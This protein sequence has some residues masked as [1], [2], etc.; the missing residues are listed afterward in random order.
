MFDLDANERLNF[1][2]QLR[3]ELEISEDPL[4][5]VVDFWIR[6]PFVNQYLDPTDPSS[7]P[8][9]WHLILDGKYDDLAIC[10]GML[11]TIKLTQRFNQSKCEIHMS[12]DKKKNEKNFFIVIDD[13]T[14]LNYQ[15]GKITDIK[16]IK[17][18]E[19]NTLWTVK[20]L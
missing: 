2:K 15:Y 5:K 7:W 12:I 14:V 6:A 13:N 3:E 19:T 1:W 10:L 9:P 17:N 4:Q 18:Q 8:D 11:Y 20:T 16:D